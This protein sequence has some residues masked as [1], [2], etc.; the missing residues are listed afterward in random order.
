MKLEE[1]KNRTADDWKSSPR[2]ME[3]VIASLIGIIEAEGYNPCMSK[4]IKKAYDIIGLDR[5]ELA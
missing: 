1:W 5:G 4:Y 3:E 2:E